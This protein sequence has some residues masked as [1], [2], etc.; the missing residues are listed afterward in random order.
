MDENPRS[1]EMKGRVKEAAG[2]LKGDDELRDEGRKDRAQGK[3]GQA[4][5]KLKDAAQDA[6]DA[7]RR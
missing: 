7:L 3:L 5:E 6:K 4:T 1:E 2:A